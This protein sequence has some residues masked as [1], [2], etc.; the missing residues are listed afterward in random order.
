MLKAAVDVFYRGEAAKAVCF[1]FG[2][3]TSIEV[4]STHTAFVHDVQPYEPGA[5]YKRELPCIL[6][7]LQ[8]V[9][10]SLV[11]TIIVDGYVWLDAEG[12]KG[13]GAHLYE[14]LQERVAVIGVAKT[15]FFVGENV[16][17]IKR[18]ESQNPL[19]V[20][21]AGMAV[22]KAA[23]CIC[24]MAGD[25]RMPALLQYLDRKTKE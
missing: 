4:F 14:A 9:N 16:V 5:F 13:L 8:Q 1:L 19:F 23:E 3:W 24:S 20:T 7:V 2:T 11:D 12:R 22:Q 21:A 10:L 17:E 25:Y 18:G 6:E 15:R